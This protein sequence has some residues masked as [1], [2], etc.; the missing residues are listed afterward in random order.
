LIYVEEFEI[1]E[2]AMKRELFLKSPAG[3]NKLQEIKAAYRMGECD[4][5]D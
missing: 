4:V 3:W 5:V 2:D 1:R